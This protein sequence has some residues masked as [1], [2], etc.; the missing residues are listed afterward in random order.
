MQ[1]WNVESPQTIDIETDVRSL[2]VRLVAGHVDVVTSD[3]PARIE[4]TDIDGS[5][6][7]VR[8][9]AGRLSIGHEELRWEGV[10]SLI[11]MPR[12]RR[13]AVVSIAVPPTAAVTVAVV[14]ADAV[15]SGLTSGVKVRCVSGDVT[16]D[17]TSGDVQVESVSGDVEGRGVSGNVTLKSVSGSLTVVDGRLQKV[18]AR[19]VSGDVVLDVRTSEGLAIDV[20]TVSGDVT[21]RLPDDTGL[22]V[23]LLTTSGQLASAFDG[24]CVEKRPG[25][26]KLT[27]RV[28]GGD[29]EL[30]G[31]TVSGSVAVLVREPA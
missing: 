11:R 10:L 19:S 22:D 15:M 16:L 12:E 7:H 20:T 28:G 9:D 29:G 25:V 24:L 5:P 26:S 27:G 18:R 2:A 23:D 31:R 8:L 1:E 6:L 30:R 13:R 17:E 3:G 14:S 4:V 21:V